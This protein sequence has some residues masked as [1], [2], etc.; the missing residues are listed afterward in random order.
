[1]PAPFGTGRMYPTYCLKEPGY[2]VGQI[3]G[4]VIERLPVRISAEAAAEFSSPQSTLCVDS[5]SVSVPFHPRVTAVARKRPLSFCQKRRWQVTP[6]HAYTL[7]PTKPEW[8]DYAAVQALWRNLSR[9][10][11]TRN[12]SGNTRPHRLRS[13]S[14]CGPILA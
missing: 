13:P 8:A 7:D 2:L 9:N 11:L 14:H 3:A 1:M 10:E 12:W 6:K 5:Y 4:L